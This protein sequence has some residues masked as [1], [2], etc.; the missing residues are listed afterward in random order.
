MQ[1]MIGRAAQGL[2]I[3]CT[4]FAAMT[5]RG[6]AEELKN[7]RHGI[8]QA[9]SDAGILMMVTQHDFAARHGLKIEIIQ[10]KSD[11]P[12]VQAAIAGEIDS[13]EGGVPSAISADAHGANVQVLGCHW[14]GLPHGIFTKASVKSIAELKGRTFAISSPG[15]MPDTLVRT[16]LAKYRIKPSEV[17][18]ANLGGDLDRYKALQAGVVDAAVVSGEYEPIAKKA[19]LR[20]LVRGSDVLPNF[21]RICIETSDKVLEQKRDL[22]ADFLAAEMDALRY[23]LSHKDEVIALTRQITGAK[24]D[25]PRPGYIFDQAKDGGVDPTIAIPMKKLEWMQRQMLAAGKIVKPIDLTKYVAPD[26]RRKALSLVRQ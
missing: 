7:W 15:A 16:V 22:A 3:A 17:Y 2:F 10:F 18:F 12:E 23:A 11:V 4:V 20:L 5:T 24:S 19:G 26:V 6:S 21:M 8:L 9:K 1:K 13:F 14:P 25:D